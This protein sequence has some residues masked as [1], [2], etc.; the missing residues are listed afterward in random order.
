[1]TPLCF[2]RLPPG[3]LFQHP[4]KV[5]ALNCRTTNYES[6]PMRIHKNFS[7]VILLLP[8]SACCAYS[9]NAK[10]ELKIK[11]RQDKNTQYQYRVPTQSHSLSETKAHR[12]GSG[13]SV[14]CSASTET[15]TTTSRSRVVEY[16]VSGATLTLLLPEGIQLPF[17]RLN[18]VLDYSQP[19]STRW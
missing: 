5:Q 10:V 1:M 16:N 15:R 9:A 2:N 8:F 17:F 12:N 4:A 14:N 6:K 7:A 11:D 19:Q 18:D 13:D 3:G